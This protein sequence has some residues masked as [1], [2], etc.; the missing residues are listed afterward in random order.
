[1]KIPKRISQKPYKNSIKI[2]SKFYQNS[3]KNPTKTSKKNPFILLHC[4][5]I[6]V[7]DFYRKK[8]IYINIFTGFK[9]EILKISGPVDMKSARADA[10]RKPIPGA[11][12]SASVNKTIVSDTCLT[13]AQ[14]PSHKWN[15]MLW[16]FTAGPSDSNVDQSTW[17]ERCVSNIIFDYWIPCRF[18]G[19]S[20]VYDAVTGS[21][22]VMSTVSVIKRLIWIVWRDLSSTLIHQWHGDI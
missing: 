16:I 11:S 2:L 9:N 19:K 7:I 8:N 17:I 10:S 5:R 20:D 21:P 3:I 1:M 12:L 6:L 4:P 18:M 22:Q 15:S 14:H 13:R